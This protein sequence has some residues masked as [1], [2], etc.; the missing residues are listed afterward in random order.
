MENEGRCMY[1]CERGKID[2]GSKGMEVW[3]MKINKKLLS[4]QL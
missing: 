2:G 3:G 1:K 4:V